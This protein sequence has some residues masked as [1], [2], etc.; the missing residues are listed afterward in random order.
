M[1]LNKRMISLIACC[2]VNLCLGSI[3]SWSVFSQAMSGYLNETAGLSLTS[4]DLAIVYTVA[5]CLG[6][7]TMIA[8]GRVNDRFGPKYVIMTGGAMYSVGLILSGFARSVGALVLFYGIIGGLGLGMAYVSV[9]STAVRLFPQKRGL[10]GGI[11]TASYGISSVLL[12][13]IVSAI[14][15][16]SNA[17]FAFKAVGVAF[18]IIIVTASLFISVSEDGSARAGA[19]AGSSQDL[20]WKAMI[21]TPVFYVM[22]FLLI[23][24][25]F[26]GMMVISQASAIGVTVMAFEAGRAAAAVSLLALF[27]TMGRIIAGMLSDRFGRIGTLRLACVLSAAAELCLLWSGPTTPV[28]F[29]VGIC[30]VGISFGSFMG[31]YPGFTAD[32]FGLRNSSVN[33]GVMCIGFGLAGYFGP[34]IAKGVFNHT[35]SYHNAFLA[36]CVFSVVGLVLTFVYQMITKKSRQ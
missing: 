3:Y 9:I 30:M 34:Q 4:G 16:K 35:G 29:Y 13:P 20:N 33:Y 2:L 1:R 8:G 11:T 6:I 19:A 27:N 5:S 17:S 7:V 15:A 25:A 18:L 32:R 14:I 28:L 31:V 26:S 21:R 36:A 12:P 24:G 23:C 10:M 22:M